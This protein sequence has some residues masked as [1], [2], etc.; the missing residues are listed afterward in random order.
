M[1]PPSSGSKNNPSKKPAG[2]TLLVPEDGGYM[3]QKN[4]HET[5]NK[6]ALLVHEDGGDMILRNVS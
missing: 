5:G 6:Q 1:S 2:S 4:Q 3:L